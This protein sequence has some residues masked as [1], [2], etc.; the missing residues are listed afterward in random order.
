[1]GTKAQGK[2]AISNKGIRDWGLGC[3]AT[4]Q[5]GTKAQGKKAISTRGSGIGKWGK[6]AKVS[7]E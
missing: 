3:K 1:M 7:N 4:R 2:K 5:M 6:G